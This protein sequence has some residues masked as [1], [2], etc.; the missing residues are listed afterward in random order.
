MDWIKKLLEANTDADGNVDTEA[1]LAAVKTDAPKHSV[2]RDEFNAKNKALQE[3]TADLKKLQDNVGDPAATKK[4]I[5]DANQR[6]TDAESKFAALQ[7]ETSI[8]EA[9][10]SAGAKDVDYMLHKLGADVDV[11]KVS[12]LIKDLQ[13]DHPTFFP[14]AEGDKP[15][16]KDGKEDK[17]GAG[18][19]YET[20][21]NALKGGDNAGADKQAAMDALFGIPVQSS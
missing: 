20:V 1:F 13:K 17:G 8:R 10:T 2:P 15:D 12:S 19:G 5:D 9:L 3:A 4:L 6:A 14:E 7:K 16:D 21:D 11:E 18:F